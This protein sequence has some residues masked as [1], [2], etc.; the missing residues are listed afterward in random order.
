MSRV[1]SEA[2]TRPREDEAH[3][4]GSIRHDDGAMGNLMCPRKERKERYHGGVEHYT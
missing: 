1:D 2:L 3:E 4:D